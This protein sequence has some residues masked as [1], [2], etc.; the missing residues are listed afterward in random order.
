MEPFTLQ[1][2]INFQVRN[3][4]KGSGGD[5]LKFELHDLNPESQISN[6]IF[7]ANTPEEKIDLVEKINTEIKRIESFRFDLGN[8]TM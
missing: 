3:S 4:S 2:Y 5:G 6:L 8:P 1:I 7:T